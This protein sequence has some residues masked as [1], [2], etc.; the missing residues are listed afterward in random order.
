MTPRISEERPHTMAEL[1]RAP[2]I[3]LSAAPLLK[4]AVDI[5]W[6]VL[7]VLHISQTIVFSA[8]HRFP[9]YLDARLTNL[10][11]EHMH[12]A[13]H[14]SIAFLNPQQFHPEHGTLL[15]SEA[16]WG[17]FLYYSA[18]RSLG[19]SIHGAFQAWEIL[20]A[21]LNAVAAWI[22]MRTLRVPW[23]C[24]GPLAFVA[25]S[26]SMVAGKLG[27]PQTLPLYAVFLTLAAL[28][29]W[30]ETRSPVYIALAAIAFANVHFACM[31]HGFF[32]SV[33]LALLV[34]LLVA[35]AWPDIIR[36]VRAY[37]W[38]AIG[39]IIAA[40]SISAFGLLLLYSPYA[41]FAATRGWTNPI[42]ILQ[43]HSPGVSAWVSA[44][45]MS[46]LYGKALD[47]SGGTVGSY[48]KRLFPGFVLLFLPFVVIGSYLAGYRDRAA[49]L[50]VACALTVLCSIGL[51][52]SFGGSDRSLF[53]WLA[54]RVDAVRAFR[55]PGRIAYVLLP[56]QVCCL[57]LVL[58]QLANSS[59]RRRTVA[60]VLLAYVV[61][62]SAG[63]SQMEF[64]FD[65]RENQPQIMAL[66]NRL[67]QRN[68]GE[69]FA[70]TVEAPQAIEADSVHLEAFEA[71]L[72]SG[73]PCVNGYSGTEPAW[74]HYFRQE[75]TA[76]NLERAL[77]EIKTP[78]RSVEV[79]MRE[80]LLE[81]SRASADSVLRLPSRQWGHYEWGEHVDF[82]G[83]GT[84]G[85]F[86]V[87]GMGIPSEVRP[88]IATR[89]KFLFKVSPPG[90]DE[91]LKVRALPYGLPPLKEQVVR[92][93]VNGGDVGTWHMASPA[94]ADYTLRV[95]RTLLE[96][97][98]RLAMTWDLPFARTPISLGINEDKRLLSVGVYD[99][100]FVPASASVAANFY[101]WGQTVMM[102]DP[103]AADRFVAGGFDPNP[104]TWRWTIGNT[105]TLRM[106]VNASERDR[107]LQF[108]AI[109]L[110]GGPVQKQN[111]GIVVNDQSLG[112]LEM[113]HSWPEQRNVTIPAAVLRGRTTL[114]IA[115]WVPGAQAPKALGINDDA[116]ILGLALR[117]FRVE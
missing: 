77:I 95:P 112:S 31:Y 43:D 1:P 48:E 50:R 85:E 57:A 46:W 104:G 3:S 8:G 65:W 58:R 107:L 19:F 81:P 38:P 73:R 108:E 103:A 94:A 55:A 49:R 111:V 80:A 47:L 61:V 74:L 9:G 62:E 53:L 27:H 5:L 42:S 14:G 13:L 54:K 72:L 37:R 75:P 60:G 66:V 22:L 4:A 83:H 96:G 82:S 115:F 36:D 29:S 68:A 91:I 52:T 33:V 12:H 20:T 2:V 41:S 98:S 30:V 39:L 35:A 63:F 25:S 51:V 110:I 88:T 21:L 10:V 11:L 70:L 24:R 45:R 76:E 92:V 109:P 15:Y 16:H 17:T 116:R 113:T 64:S 84:S 79:F 100:A 89:A 23:W 114:D 69:P 101:S 7:A 78:P 90:E 105:G 106:V 71:A 6:I 40:L 28:F 117:W 56:L 44:Q 34:P 59:A 32:F 26:H 87:S 18:F 99:L 97:R 67:K 86:V 102:G 93:K